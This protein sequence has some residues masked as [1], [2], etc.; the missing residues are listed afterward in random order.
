MHL[1]LITHFGQKC[2]D[3]VYLL[4]LKWIYMLHFIMV[5]QQCF[6]HMHLIN[7]VDIFYSVSILK[8]TVCFIKKYRYVIVTSLQCGDLHCHHM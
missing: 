4:K 7:G 2:C 5:I 1:I 6:T 3:A 8:S